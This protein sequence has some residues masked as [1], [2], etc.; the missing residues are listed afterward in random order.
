MLKN[1]LETLLWPTFDSALKGDSFL[2][3]VTALC[4]SSV[5]GSHPSL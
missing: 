4:C 3:V 1:F 2:I 5:L